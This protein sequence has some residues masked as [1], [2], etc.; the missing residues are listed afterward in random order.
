MC[1]LT[2]RINESVFSICFGGPIAMRVK[3]RT[4]RKIEVLKLIVESRL[5][6]MLF[7]KM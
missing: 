4:E 2:K 3:I 7:M 1:T 5:L 6:L